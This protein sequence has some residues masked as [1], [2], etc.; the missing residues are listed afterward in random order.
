[1]IIGFG[2]SNEES[3]TTKKDNE[4]SIQVEANTETEPAENEDEDE[5]K[6]EWD[7]PHYEESRAELEKLTDDEVIELLNKS[8]DNKHQITEDF[9]ENEALILKTLTGEEYYDLIGMTESEVLNWLDAYHSHINTNILFADQV[10]GIDS[11]RYKEHRGVISSAKIEFEWIRDN[12]NFEKEYY[13]ELIEEILNLMDQHASGN[14]DALFDLK[15]ILYE[16]NAEF[17]PHTLK[18]E[19]ATNLSLSNTVRIQN[20][21]SPID[22]YE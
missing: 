13:N 3:Q 8:K 4:E 5:A 19:K 21:E 12:Y 6:E 10:G 9:T 17:N 15:Y 1:M 14:N 2:C 7:H 11:D 18:E 20:G 22:E 16:M